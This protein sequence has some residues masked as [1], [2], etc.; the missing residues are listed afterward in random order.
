MKVKNMTT[1]K[2]YHVANQFIITDGDIEYFQSYR[3]I[4]VKRDYKQGILQI[5]LDEHY[6]NYSPTTSKYRNLF[7]EETTK[8]TQAK[9][10]S[11]EYILTDLN[12]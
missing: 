10:D 8:E 2:G 11:G 1:A 7:L 12:Q 3:S 9:I 4:I 6:W 5:S